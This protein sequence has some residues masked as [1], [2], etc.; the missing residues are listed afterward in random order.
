MVPTAFGTALLIS[1]ALAVG[2]GA[3]TVAVV[4]PVVPVVHANARCDAD[5][6]RDK[7]EDEQEARSTDT[8]G[9]A[10]ED[11]SEE[12]AENQTEDSDCHPPHGA[13]VTP[14]PTPVVTVPPTPAPAPPASGTSAASASTH[15]AAR[16][17]AVP[18]TGV[19]DDRL[20]GLCLGASGLVTLIAGRLCG[21]RRR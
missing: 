7:A 11:S 15:S 17:S 20:L 21:R 8:A 16:I 19:G 18:K 14:S 13:K 12:S 5:K 6:A 2:G 4:T 10:A 9:D 3:L 1:G